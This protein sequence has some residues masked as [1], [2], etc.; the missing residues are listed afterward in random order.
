MSTTPNPHRIIQ[1]PGSQPLAIRV[2]PEDQ[3]P[4]CKRTM[5]WIKARKCFICLKCNEV[6]K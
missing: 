6:G 3:C 1:M 4:N 5:E 2:P